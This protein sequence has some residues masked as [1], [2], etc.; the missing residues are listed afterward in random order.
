MKIPYRF[1]ETGAKFLSSKPRGMNADDPGLGKTLQGIEAVKAIGQSAK[2]VLV[3]TLRPVRSSWQE[4][5]QEQDPGEKAY[6]VHGKL[7]AEYIRSWGLAKKAKTKYI[8]VHWE[9]VRV[10]WQKIVDWD[11]NVIIFD[12]SHKMKNRKAKVSL[13][14]QKMSTRLPDTRMFL[15]TGTP[16]WNRPEDLWNQLYIVTKRKI[17]P[18]WKWVYEHLEVR[19]LRLPSGR[20]VTKIT[21]PKDLAAFREHLRPWIIHRDKRDVMSELPPVTYEVVPLEMGTEQK[22]AYA[23]MFA[24]GYAIVD[25]QEHIA[26]NVPVKVIRLKQIA[27]SHELLNKESGGI[28]GAKLEWLEDVVESMR[29]QGKK[30]VIFSQFAHVI[31]RLAAHFEYSFPH[32]TGDTKD[33]LREGIIEQFTKGDAE[34]IFLSMG[35]G[36]VGIDGLQ[37]VSSHMVMFDWDWTP[38]VNKQA[39]GRLDRMGQTEPVT[40]WIPMVKGTIEWAIYEKVGK[41]EDIAELAIPESGPEILEYLDVT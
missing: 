27:T 40:V 11:P 17:G 2:R 29:E 30:L 5:I 9:F 7:S 25:G 41:K 34:V 24:Q 36:G 13:A 3:V 28:S 15:F 20:T 12:E 6:I 35:V 4:K 21:K 18:Y 32:I 1:Q 26:P 16:I 8:V 14:I 39:I 10:N 33:T 22:K 31:V 38:A 37:E 23:T 19:D